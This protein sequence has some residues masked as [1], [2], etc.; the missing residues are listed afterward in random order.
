MNS[1]TLLLGAAAAFMLSPVAAMAERGSSGH[2]NIIYWQAPSTLNPYL[3]G[4]TKE[5]ESASLVLESLARFDNAG[6]MVPWLATEIPTIE[7]GG[8]A[9]DLTSI[10]WTLAEG[11]MWSD[12]TALTPADLIF[13]W[14]YCTHPEGGCAQA[15]YFDGV[16]SVEDLGDNQVRVNFAAPT[17][18]PYTAFVGAESPIIQAAQFA[19]CLGARAPECTDANFGPIGTGPFVVTDFRPNDVIEFVANENF[20]FPDRPYFETVTFKGGG[21]AAA[22]ARSVLETGE[23]DYAWNLQIDPTILAQMEAQGNGTVVTAFG[24]SVERLHLNQFNPDPALGDVRSTADA[25]PHPFLTNPVIGQAMSMAIDRA[26]LVEVG[27]GAGGQPT[28]NVLP[29][30]ELYASTANDSC[31]VQ[32]IAGANALLDEAG[33]VDTNGD[34]IREAD[35]V[36]L[37]VLYQTST[38]AVRQDTQA[39]VKQWWSEIGIDAELRNIDASVF[40]GG[41]PASPDTFQKFYADIEMYTNNFAG[42]DPQAYMANW[43]C[44]EIPGPDTQWQ[45]SNIQRFCDPAYDALVDEM[46]MTADLQERGRIAREMNDMIMQSYSI[47]PLVHRGGVSA[48][49]NSLEGIRMSDWD[50]ELWNIMDWRRAE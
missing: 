27:Y 30:P 24:T 18:F 20:R 2:L 47:I 38:N 21:D 14:E 42:V 1:K 44:N 45:G 33:I 12:G 37:Q 28:C 25:G 5:V 49:A 9:E 34:G 16:T 50:S 17:P 39:L 15:S 48:H 43:R 11:V 31:L 29:A 40:F 46:A 36:P 3:S 8:V 35:G 6:T 32:D 22:A 19:E 4:G 13:T 10:T 41:D 7:N 23:F 26:L